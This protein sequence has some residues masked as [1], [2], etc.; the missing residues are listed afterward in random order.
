MK[1]N[2]FKI[3]KNP[4]FLA[5]LLCVVGSSSLF[6]ADSGKES[7]WDYG[8]TIYL[9]GANIT[10]NT[11][12]SSTDPIP[13]YKL[14]DNLQMAFM[15]GFEARK[16]KLS[17]FADLIY[18]DVKTKKTNPVGPGDGIETNGSVELTSWIFTPQVRYALVDDEKSRF[19]LVAGL[20]YLDLS[21]AAKIN[22]EDNP[23]LDAEKSGSDWDGIIGARWVINLNEKWFVPLYAD[24]GAG[25]SDSTWQ[26]LGGIGYR[27]KRV[28][29][30]LAYRHLQYSFDG[31]TLLDNMVIKGPM[32][33][34]TFRF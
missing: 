20:R 32:G 13:F 5:A 2:V 19:E 10:A 15:G 34:V 28:E 8:A 23:I 3:N 17:L 31:D 26:A 27:F 21:T 14:L 25:G 24:V 9:W 16:D 12:G 1:R 33:G 22:V 7:D 29:A 11:A 18:L 6:A 4:I 30:M